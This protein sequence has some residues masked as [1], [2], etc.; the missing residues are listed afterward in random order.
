[1]NSV[2]MTLKGSRQAGWQWEVT[3]DGAAIY[4]TV[5]LT[6]N[7]LAWSLATVQR[8]AE[9]RNPLFDEVTDD[10][11]A[12]LLTGYF[13]GEFTDVLR[14]SA[15]EQVWAKHR[16]APALPTE[17][18][19]FLFLVEGAADDADRLIVADGAKTQTYH[20]R[21]GRFDALLRDIQAR[22]EVLQPTK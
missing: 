17:V 13:A 15:E 3:I 14:T 21:S 18:G 2:D 22:L 6:L 8:D 19:M 16:V 9:R 11:L 10:K 1:M 12:L 20:V 5:P 7:D 4:R